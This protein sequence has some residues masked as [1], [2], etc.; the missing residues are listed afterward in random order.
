MFTFDF[1]LLQISHSLKASMEKQLSPSW[2]V[3]LRLLLNEPGESCKMS[4]AYG[5]LQGCEFLHFGRLQKK[6]FEL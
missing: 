6:L 2:S 1:Q 3:N 4:S 5:L